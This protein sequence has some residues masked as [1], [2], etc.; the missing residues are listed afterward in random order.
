MV[1]CDVVMVKE[2][3]GITKCYFS[4]SPKALADTYAL[5]TLQPVTVNDAV[6]H[7]STPLF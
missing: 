4:L 1:I 7:Y 2:G 6:S 5:I 3:E